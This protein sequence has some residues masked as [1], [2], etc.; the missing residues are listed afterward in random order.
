MP[1]RFL[2]D[3]HVEHE[4]MHRLDERGYAV[5]HVEFHSDLGKGASDTSLSS[6][7][8][9]TQRIIVTYDGDFLDHFEESEYYGVV[10]FDDE[11]LSAKQVADIID[12]MA[13][14]YP[15]E[16]FQGFEYGTRDWL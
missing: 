7:S 5:E 9:D 6:F 16:D 14:Q 13:T 11:S 2:L 3:E 12:T 15:T 8:L 10:Y 4:V 1:V